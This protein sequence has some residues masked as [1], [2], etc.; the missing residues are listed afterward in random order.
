MFFT[1]FIVGGT[2]VSVLAYKERA[3]IV[4]EWFDKHTHELIFGMVRGLF[5]GD[6]KFAILDAAPI[7]P[8]ILRFK[9]AT[10]QSDVYAVGVVLWEMLAGRRLFRGATDADTLARLDRRSQ[11][12]PSQ[13]ESSS[14]AMFIATKPLAPN[15]AVGSTSRNART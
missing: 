1:P 8:E 14:R 7:A 5:G 9:P 13:T 12:A 4:R 3:A 6:M 2:D 11:S 10:P 15:S